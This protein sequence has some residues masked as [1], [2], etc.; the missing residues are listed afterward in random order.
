MW[1]AEF[2]AARAPDSN[3]S[4]ASTDDAR[5]APAGAAPA[6]SP[7]MTLFYGEGP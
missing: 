3:A 5:S 2:S 6:S 4:S 7:A 1:A